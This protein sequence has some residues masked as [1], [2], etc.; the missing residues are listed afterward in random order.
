MV[1]NYVLNRKDIKNDYEM[2]QRRLG[3]SQK[4]IG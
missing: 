3:W 2:A 4:M 1:G